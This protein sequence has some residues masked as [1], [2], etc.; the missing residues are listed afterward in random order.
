MAYFLPLYLPNSP[1]NENFKKHENHDMLYCSW[2]MVREECNCHFSFWAIFWPFT[3][4]TVRKMK[5]SKNEKNAWYHHFTLV[6]HAYQ[7]LWLDDVR[8]LRYGARRT[9]GRTDGWKKWHIEVGATP[10]NHIGIAQDLGRSL[11]YQKLYCKKYTQTSCFIC[12]WTVIERI[13]F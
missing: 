7:K 3:P 6:Y 5:I 4:V 9:D 10:K 8:L 2:D 13:Y 11:K 1:K 12:L